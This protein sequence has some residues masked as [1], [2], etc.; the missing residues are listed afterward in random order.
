M[1]RALAI[2]T[3]G[4][5]GSL[6]LLEDDAVVAEEQFP[7]GLR[8]AAQMLPIIDRLVGQRQWQPADLRE[9]YISIGP[10]SFTGLRIGVTLAK[11]LAFA[12][13]ARIAGIRTMH[14]LA[15]N[16]PVGWTNALIILDAKRGQIFTARFAHESGALVEKEPAH[17]DRLADV[18]A[19]C[20]RPVHL[21]G[22]GIP[23]HRQFIPD[24]DPLIFITPQEAWRPRAAVVGE[25]GLEQSRLGNFADPYTLAPLYLRLPEAEEKRLADD[26]AATATAHSFRT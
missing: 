12:T 1:P 15:R 21:I 26:A 11:T 10:G 17:L 20:P 4:Q 24:N 8:H 5:V 19:R 9:I 14:V 6:A 16:A 7:H 25:L 2:E 18:L 22:E 3:S 13:G 23:Y